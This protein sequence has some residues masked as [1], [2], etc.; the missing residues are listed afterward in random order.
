MCPYVVGSEDVSTR[1]NHVIGPSSSIRAAYG[2][3]LYLSTNELLDGSDVRTFLTLLS[4]NF[5]TDGHL[6]HKGFSS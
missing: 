6:V 2:H 1:Q 5:A 4:I 3:F